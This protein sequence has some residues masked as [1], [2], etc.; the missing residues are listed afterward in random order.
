VKNSLPPRLVAAAAIGSLASVAI[1]P[2]L[3]ADEQSGPKSLPAESAEVFAPPAAAQPTNLEEIIGDMSQNSLQEAFRILRSDYIQHEQLTYLELNRA[4]LQGLLNRLEFGA[5]LLNGA[6]RDAQDSPFDFHHQALSRN[7]AYLRPGKFQVEE[8]AAL[9]EALKEFNSK[10]KLQTLIIDLRSP[11]RSADFEIAAQFLSRFRGSG[12][13]LFKITRP[14]E[15]R[16]TLFIA[17]NSG[18]SWDRELL[19]LIDQE[20]GNV[21]EIIAAVLRRERDAMVIGEATLGLTVE[22]RDVPLEDDRYL[23]YAVAEVLLADDS[24]LFRKGVAPD[25][26]ALTPAVDKHAVFAAV[27]TEDKDLKQFLYDRLRPRMNEAALVA[28]TD[29]EL[30][31]YLA[32]SQGKDT[33]Y[34][35]APLQDRTLQQTLDLLTTRDFLE[36]KEKGSE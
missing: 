14:G 10:E 13:L 29:P 7:V 1:L 36:L 2:S 4:A 5:T 30:E 24:S 3:F 15:S 22:Y 27:D 12:E 32:K 17:E 28:G 26:P 33:P 18:G 25:L 19:V 20:T 35:K 31:Y 23:R 9:D 16:P 11:Q 6:G 34:D 8:I 21:G